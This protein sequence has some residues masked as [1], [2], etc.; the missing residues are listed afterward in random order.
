MATFV[1]DQLT[2]VQATPFQPLDSS[3]S[4]GK[5]R[6]KAFTWTGTA[7]QNDIVQFCTLPKGARV[8]S[9]RVDLGAFGTSVTFAMGDGTTAAKYLAASTTAAA[10]GQVD[11]ANTWALY[12]LAREALTAGITLTG[13]IG[14][15]APSG[16][17]SIRGVVRYI[18]E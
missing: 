13:T 10:G 7:A 2:K 16:S 3:F 18:V 15:A 12:G 11:F 8:T 9:G 6:E 1:S 4:E 17:A 5:V 14:G